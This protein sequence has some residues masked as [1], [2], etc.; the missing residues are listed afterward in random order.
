[1]DVSYD[2]RDILNSGKEENGLEEK[3]KDN[4]SLQNEHIN[5]QAPNAVRIKA[6]KLIRYDREY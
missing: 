3:V 2:V 1:M 4:Q 6:P 5:G